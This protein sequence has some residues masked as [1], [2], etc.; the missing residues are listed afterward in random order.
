MT[1]QSHDLRIT[2]TADQRDALYEVVFLHLSGIEAVVFAAAQRNFEEAD[3]LGRAFSDDLLLVLDDL[4]WG[5]H[6]G[7]VEL[8]SSPDVLRRVLERVRDVAEAEDR[9]EAEERA[10][11]AEHQRRNRL[12]QE[13]CSRVLRALDHT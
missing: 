10:E 1:T 11:L 6:G 5:E 12:V 9:D 2:I 13:T 8:K 4:G 3:R 7:S